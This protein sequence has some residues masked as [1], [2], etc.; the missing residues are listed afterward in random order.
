MVGAHLLFAELHWFYL[1][2]IFLNVLF[3][4]QQIPTISVSA[5][6]TKKRL[7]EHEGSVHLGDFCK[8]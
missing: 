6:Y 8:S 1:L 5:L 2:N 3:S 7:E 4:Q